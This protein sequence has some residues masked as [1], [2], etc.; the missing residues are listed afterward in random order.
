MARWL[1]CTAAFALSGCFNGILLTPTHVGGPLE[2]TVIADAKHCLCRHKVLII[3]VDGIIMNARTSGLL[4]D[5]ENPVSLF[6]ERLDEAADDPH[7]KAVVLR[8]NS[9]GGA[10]T[11]SD[12]MYQDLVNFRRDTHKPVVACMMDVA[13]S[14]AYYLAMGCDRIYAHPTTVT[15]SIGVIMSLYN[16]SGLFTKIGVTSDPIKSGPNKDLGN[17]GRPMTPEERAI[18]QGMVDS[19]YAQF[20]QVVARGRGLPEDRVRALADGR[21]YTGVDAKKLGLVDEIGYLEDALQT[22]MSMAHI[23]DAAVIAYDRGDGY[24]GSIYAGMPKIPSEINVKL[25]VPGLGN[26]GRAAFMYL[27]EPGAQ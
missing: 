23:D 5:G 19:F 18:L 8:I 27:W 4:S 15:G 14:G 13:A 9:P 10:V 1:L 17:P 12:I 6:R 24:R 2:E 20:V 16:A 25:D 21:V 3:D 22:A 26:R 7:V 11:A